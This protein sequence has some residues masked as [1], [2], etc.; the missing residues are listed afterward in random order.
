MSIIE[1]LNGEILFVYLISI[2]NKNFYCLNSLLLKIIKL[3]INSS[4]LTN[5]ELILVF[6]ITKDLF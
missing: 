4:N 1:D 3:I 6:E 2:I 5:Y